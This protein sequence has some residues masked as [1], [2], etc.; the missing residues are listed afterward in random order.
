MNIDIYIGLVFMLSVYLFVDVM[1]SKEPINNKIRILI[2]VV[3]F[4]IL[5]SAVYLLNYKSENNKL[6]WS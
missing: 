6:L 4:V 1:C 3:A 5:F 2:Y